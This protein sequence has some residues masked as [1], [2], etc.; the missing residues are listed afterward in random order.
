MKLRRHR[1]CVLQF[2]IT[3][4]GEHPRPQY[5]ATRLKWGVWNGRFEGKGGKEVLKG[6]DCWRGEKRGSEGGMK[7]FMKRAWCTNLREPR[8]DHSE[9]LC[10][11]KCT[12]INCI[13]SYLN[14]YTHINIYI[15]ILAAEHWRAKDRY[16]PH[17]KLRT[18][19][20][21]FNGM[22]LAYLLRAVPTIDLTFPLRDYHKMK[23]H[24][25]VSACTAGAKGMAPTVV[26]WSCPIHD[27][28][29]KLS[30]PPLLLLCIVFRFIVTARGDKR[31]HRLYREM[32]LRIITSLN[33]IFHFCG[34]CR[35][36]AI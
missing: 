9:G 18:D 5:D 32:D 17:H 28:P 27:C 8:N 26:Q 12:Y 22:L 31:W 23:R 24:Y 34:I 1:T 30:A 15:Y 25:R 10:Y 7:V 19:V 4:I 2:V 13:T 35:Y 6:S 36:Y 20:L 11:G 3:S 33:Q 14:I 21:H 16:R 29:M